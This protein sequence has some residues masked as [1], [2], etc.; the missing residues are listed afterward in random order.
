MRRTLICTVAVLS[1]GLG[2]LMVGCE[3]TVSKHSETK[4]N[5]DGTT[6]K[7]EEKVTR[8]ADGSTSKTQTVDVDKPDTNKDHDVKVKVDTK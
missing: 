7:R 5:S 4:T 1:L 6:V 2:G 3:D 8:N